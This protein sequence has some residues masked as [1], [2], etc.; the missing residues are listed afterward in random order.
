VTI[1][2]FENDASIGRQMF[3]DQPHDLRAILIRNQMRHRIVG[4][5]D[6]IERRC[7]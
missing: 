5:H 3:G 6:Q 2:P 1:Q 7:K 4:K